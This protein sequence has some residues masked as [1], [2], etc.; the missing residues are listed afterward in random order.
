MQTF[1]QFTIDKAHI[2]PL[3]SQIIICCFVLLLLFSLW[4]PR[5]GT[6]L[7]LELEFC[8]L[9]IVKGI[10]N[11]LIDHDYL[12]CQKVSLS[13][14]DFHL[15]REDDADFLGP[16]EVPFIPQDSLQWVTLRFPF[17]FPY[18]TVKATDI[19]ARR[20][21]QK[22]DSCTRKRVAVGWST[23]SKECAEDFA[24]FVELSPFRREE[25]K[26]LYCYDYRS[27]FLAFSAN[28]GWVLDVSP[29]R[30]TLLLSW[31][32]WKERGVLMTTYQSENSCAAV[33]FSGTPL[34]NRISIN[35]EHLE[36]Q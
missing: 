9:W 26:H 34:Y 35:I 33:P 27:L 13:P 17:N 2:P 14:L 4:E 18:I 3:P 20:A 21:G 28:L 31:K 36:M 22:P 5:E 32:E 15:L 29:P 12:T 1:S 11:S 30:T 24:P 10:G 7:R 6:N 23:T 16:K 25:R 19:L 8:V